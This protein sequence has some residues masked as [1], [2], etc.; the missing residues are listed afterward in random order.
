MAS[1]LQLLCAYPVLESL[2]AVLPLGDLFNLSKTSSTI[3]ITLHGF[4]INFVKKPSSLG[5]VRP[6]LSIGRHD[7]SH[8][9][10]LKAKSPLCCSETQHT[11]GA[12]IK[13]CLMC[14]MPVC[15]ACIIK[16][17]FGKRDENTFPNRTRSL[18]V[19]CF[20]S[21]TPHQAAMLNGEE[22]VALPSYLMRGE[23]I[24]TAK[25]GHLCLKCKTK[26]NS[27]LETRHNQ[28][29][30]QG[31]SKSILEDFG[32][33]VCIWCDVPLPRER[34]RAESRRDYDIRHI[35]AR[36]HSSYDQSPGEETLLDLGGEEVVC[37]S[38]TSTSSASGMK[39]PTKKVKAF[40]HDRFEAERRKELEEVSE[41]RQFT[42]SA[43]EDERWRRSEN[44]RRSGSVC[45][46]SPPTRIQRP[47]FSFGAA[48]STRSC[49]DST[50]SSLVPEDDSSLPSYDSLIVQSS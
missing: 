18:C 39:T 22:T 44:L 41:R 25:D 5:A 1:L 4:S 33:R 35:L 47:S 11:R 34:S 26:Q 12:N 16:A 40:A 48:N 36:T 3:R 21:G 9:K 32:G 10:N 43:L 8:W 14:S 30:G 27:E 15:E 31:C 17:S 45:R 13:G 28:C 23:C 38:S 42:A 49:L 37:A 7:T 29:Y 24:C 19:E 2:V 46:A 6:A 50:V 20:D